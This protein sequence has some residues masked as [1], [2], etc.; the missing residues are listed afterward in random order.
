[1]SMD[2]QL[3]KLGFTR[4]VLPKLAF[5]LVQTGMLDQVTLVERLIAEVDGRIAHLRDQR[6]KILGELTA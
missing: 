5:F 6:L 2:K 3:V 1:M 4:M